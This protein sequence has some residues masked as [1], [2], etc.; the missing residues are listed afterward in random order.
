[1]CLVAFALDAHPR[2]TVVVAGNRDEAYARPTAPAAWWPDAPVLAGRDLE[3]GGTWMGVAPGGRWAVVTNVRDLPAHRP[4]DRSRGRLPTDFLMGERSPGRYAADVW[5]DREAFNPFNLLV[6]A[7]ADVAYVS[8]HA[9]GVQRVSAG[10]HGLSNATLDVPWPKTARLAARL[11]AVLAR[12]DLA[13]AHLWPLLADDAVAPD[14][15]LPETGVGLDRERALSA[16]F[17]RM[18]G[19]GTRTSQVLLL[20]ADGRGVFAERTFVEGEARETRRFEIGGPG[21]RVETLA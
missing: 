8:S 18:P 5:A 3:A 4:R 20:D 16:A 7:G 6:G 2:W 12:P 10:V 19:Y 1:M 11:E 21:P 15:A 17:I 14:D 13:P 9:D